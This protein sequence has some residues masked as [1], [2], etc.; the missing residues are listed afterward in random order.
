[1]T[2]ERIIEQVAAEGI[3]LTLGTDGKLK[4]TGDHVAVTRW[5]PIIRENKPGIVAVLTRGDWLAAW[6]GL[7]T[8]TSGLTADDPRLPVVTA[9]LNLCDD[10]YLRGNWVAFRHA[11]ARVRRAMEGGTVRAEL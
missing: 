6:R 5:L 7:A 9:A 11:A 10:A 8:L 2:P 4:A 3:R 1:M